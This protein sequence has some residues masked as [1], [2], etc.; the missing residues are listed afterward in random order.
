VNVLV[1]GATGFLGQCVVAKAVE[2][3]H[4]V[5]AMTGP[6]RETA[7]NMFGS[8]VAQVRADLRHRGE[9]ATMLG[10][11]EVVIHAAAAAGGER[12][13][14][15]ASTVVGTENLLAALQDVAL[16]RF[17]HISS[18]SVYDFHALRPGA[19]LDETSRVEASPSER[20]AYTE[21]KIAQEMLVREWCAQRGVPCVILRPGAIV[22]PG[23]SWGDGAE[24]AAGP[25]SVVVAPR[26]LF[27]MVSLSN[28]A[29]AIVKAIDA[30]VSGTV[31][32]NIVDEELPTNAE[33]FRLCRRLGAPTGTM[34]PVP[35][36]V[37]DLV[38]R[39][40]QMVS[41]RWLD[42]RLRLPE[43]LDHRRQE[44]R[45]KPLRYPNDQA[46]RV[47]GWRSEQDA[48]AT[49]RTTRASAGSAHHG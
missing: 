16:E 42:G 18:F 8:S 33:Y 39:T 47:L 5:V 12:A 9:W 44:A 14:Q 38:G 32:L 45:W 22:G 40:L 25:F 11:T 24:L 26:A 37:L 29:E 30:P 13:R 41:R 34:L 2:A 31:T 17:I 19:V 49:A 35:W 15:L 20:D 7:S 43:L 27:R 48:A 21:S 6:H 4:R 46:R 23:K 36:M 10:A 1:T 28:C 3:N